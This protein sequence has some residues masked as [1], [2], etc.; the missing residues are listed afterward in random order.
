MD[1]EEAT[2]VSHLAQNALRGEFSVRVM[3]METFSECS[4]CEVV[5]KEGDISMSTTFGSIVEGYQEAMQRKYEAEAQLAL[6]RNIRE[7]EA[8][9]SR[10]KAE[11]ARAQAEAERNRLEALYRQAQVQYQRDRNNVQRAEFLAEWEARRA[12]IF[13]QLLFWEQELLLKRSDVAERHKQSWERIRQ[14]ALNNA[15][16]LEISK[17]RAIEGQ[18][19]N[20][21]LEAQD[22]QSRI[23][24]RDETHRHNQQTELQEWM[25]Q[26]ARL[27]EMQRH[28]QAQESDQSRRTYLMEDNYL[29][30]QRVQDRRTDL[31]WQNNQVQQQIACARFWET[32]DHNVVMEQLQAERS[33]SHWGKGCITMLIVV[34]ILVVLFLCMAM[35]MLNWTHLK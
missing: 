7:R 24:R 32:V 10:Q 16:M 33:G 28:N 25:V 27:A 3:R 30:G 19:H 26:Q 8:H 21:T 6:D 14:E 13:G 35:A 4:V 15:A 22:L 12:R 34:A 11:A 20:Q 31:I 2:R 23:D 18:R 5:S 9:N 1:I 29:H 17:W